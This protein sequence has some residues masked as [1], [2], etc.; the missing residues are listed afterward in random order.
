MYPLL[1][2]VLIFLLIFAAIDFKTNAIPSIFLTGLLFV[3]ATVEST[4]IV[5]YGVLTFIMAW[6]FYE[7]D[8]FSGIAD[9]KIMTIVGLLVNSVFFLG[10]YLIMILI[11]G[12]T[13]KYGSRKILK[14]TEHAAFIPVFV[15]TYIALWVVGGVLQ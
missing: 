9:V 15:F 6:L 7:A 11:F 12:I 4:Q 2:I 8:V 14:E 3:V 13:W 1:I 5:P 10:A